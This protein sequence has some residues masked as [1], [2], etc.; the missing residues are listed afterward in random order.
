MQCAYA[1][2]RP[3]LQPS[4]SSISTSGESYAEARGWTV[5]DAPGFQIEPDG[6]IK[7]PEFGRE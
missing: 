4:N 7:L 1:S 5:L 3:S 2:C 6:S